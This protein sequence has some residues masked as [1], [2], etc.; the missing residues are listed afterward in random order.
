MGDKVGMDLFLRWMAFTVRYPAVR[1]PWSPVIVSDYHGVGKGWLY[2]LF[3]VL[4]GPKNA[5]F[6]TPADLT[7]SRAAFNEWL[8]GTVL[9]ID[10]LTSA[11]IDL[12]DFLKPII[13][14]TSAWINSKYG[15]KQFRDIFCNVLCFTNRKDAMK[16][17]EQDRRFWI[18]HTT[19]APKGPQ[20]YTNLHKWLHGQGPAYLLGFLEAIDLTT[21]K[22]NAPP[23]VTQAKKMMIAYGK[24]EI[25]QCVEDSYEMVV[26]PFRYDIITTQLACE[27][28]KQKCNLERI[29]QGEKTYIGRIV[30]RLHPAHLPQEKYRI[31]YP[32]GPSYERLVLIR[33]PERWKN[34]QAN[35]IRNYFMSIIKELN[36]RLIYTDVN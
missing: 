20:Y 26:G 7:G 33:N 3:K 27:W 29:S 24:S 18:L 6:L 8:G 21:F 23:P 11:K 9:V 36:Q 22:W 14:E 10:E 30:N 1:I 4:S 17:I 28:V 32:S 16:M 35:E 19:A 13:T 15:K 5:H 25:E 31:N 12:Y 34:T 2:H